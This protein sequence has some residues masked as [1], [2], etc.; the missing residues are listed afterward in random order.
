VKVIEQIPRRVIDH[1][2]SHGFTHSR[3]A[4]GETYVSIAELDGTIGGHPASSQQLLVVLRGA[5]TVS[6]RDDEAELAEGAAVLWDEGEW[7]ETRG[8]AL[9]LLV[10]GTF[11]TFVN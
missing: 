11:E 6:T 1:Y 8:H 7:H 5:V 3:L 9:L 2:G 10:E 4:L